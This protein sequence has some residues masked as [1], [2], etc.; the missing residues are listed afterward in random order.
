MSASYVGDGTC[1]DA[2]GSSLKTNYGKVSAYRTWIKSK[3]SG[4]QD[5]N[6]DW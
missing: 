6:C 5:N 4:V 2:V 3:T 1:N